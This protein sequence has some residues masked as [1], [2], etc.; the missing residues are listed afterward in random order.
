MIGFISILPEYVF[1]CHD[2]RPKYDRFCRVL[3]PVISLFLYAF[4]S[5][6][7]YSLKLSASRI[8][9]ASSHDFSL[10]TSN[11]RITN[12]ESQF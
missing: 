9:N 10:I 11:L 6:E 3:E 1:S 8:I 12:G 2:S 7:H 4:V 5:L